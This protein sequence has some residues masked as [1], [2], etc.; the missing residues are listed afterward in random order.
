MNNTLV[1]ICVQTYNHGSTIERC[2]LSL[3]DQQCSF[4]FEILIHDDASTDNTQEIIQRYQEKHPE[5]IKP[6][7]QKQNR[8]SHGI[9]PNLTFNFPRAKGEFIALCEGDDYWF[10]RHKLTKQIEIMN[11]NTDVCMTF[12]RVYYEKEGRLCVECEPE[13]IKNVKTGFV[14]PSDLIKHGSDFCP[15]PSVVFR[16]NAYQQIERYFINNKVPVVDL[17]LQILF[18]HIGKVYILEAQMAVYTV[19]APGSWTNSKIANSNQTNISIIKCLINCRSFLIKNAFV[20]N[21]KILWLILRYFRKLS[22]GLQVGLLVSNITLLKLIF[23]AV[24]NRTSAAIRHVIKE[25]QA[26]SIV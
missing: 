26:N 6:I 5:V 20:P 21:T 13:T 25:E 10:D 3:L 1:S 18:A 19:S 16:T 22:I 2:I 11:L 23:L 24:V 12:H 9:R 14:R 4:D 15:T 8:Y 17:F 7:F